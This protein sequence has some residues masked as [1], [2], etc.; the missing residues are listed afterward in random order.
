VSRTVTDEILDKA[1]SAYNSFGDPEAPAC[2]PPSMRA[3]L[4][5]VAPALIADYQRSPN[6][7]RDAYDAQA[8][9]FAVERPKLIAQGMREAG[10]IIDASEGDVDFAKFKL[11]SRA[12]ELDPK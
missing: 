1:E 8:E 2:D 9:K 10:E 4:E 3:A 5:A 11:Q 7:L 12:Q 6:V